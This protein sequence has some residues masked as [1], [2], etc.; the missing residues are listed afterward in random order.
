MSRSTRIL[1]VLVMLVL[2]TACGDVTGP[3]TID[4]HRVVVIDSYSGQRPYEIDVDE[5][6]RQ[7]Y[8]APDGAYAYVPCIEPG[9]DIT[10]LDCVLFEVARTIT[11]D[12]TVMNLCLDDTGSELY[13]ISDCALWVVSVPSGAVADSILVPGNCGSDIAH[14]PGT[15]LVYASAF[16]SDSLVVIDTSP[17]EIDTAYSVTADKL[18]IPPDGSVLY[19][20]NGTELGALDP[21]DGTI[22]G[23]VD[24]GEII[25]GICAVPG[26]GYI[27]VSWSSL[28]SDTGGVLEIDAATLATAQSL[29]LGYPAE[30]VCYVPAVGQLYVGIE[31]ETNCAVAAVDLPVM[32][33]FG[34]IDLSTPGLQGLCTVPS[35]GYVLCSICYSN[36]VDY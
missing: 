4:V 28:Q 26:S 35:G 2:L 13:C 31:K 22:L 11:L 34:E 18:F 15:D 27:Y 36:E 17:L 23:T 8:C 30:A 10:V 5:G 3:L 1:P 20:T 21:D 19:F 16:F 12:G 25:T 6:N 14:R 29:D 33:L 9:P 7:V 24:I 32:G